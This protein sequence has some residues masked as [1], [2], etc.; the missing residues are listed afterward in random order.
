[1]ESF[2][3]NRQSGIHGFK[4][5]VRSCTPNFDVVTLSVSDKTFQNVSQIF[6]S[7]PNRKLELSID[8]LII[9]GSFLDFIVGN[10]EK[11]L[12]K[13]LKHVAWEHF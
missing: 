3:R 8:G 11:F 9:L 1:M 7:H 4:L 2:V 10:R 13:S 6:M 5:R 12:V